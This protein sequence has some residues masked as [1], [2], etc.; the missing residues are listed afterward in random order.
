MKNYIKYFFSRTEHWLIVLIM[1]LVMFGAY[2]QTGDWASFIFIV[3]IAAMIVR[4]YLMY[5]KK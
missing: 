1:V 4:S 2:I 5:K 3:P